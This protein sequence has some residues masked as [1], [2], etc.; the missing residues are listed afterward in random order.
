MFYIKKLLTAIAIA[1]AVLAAVATSNYYLGSIWTDT[2]VLILLLI[3]IAFQLQLGL[4]KKREISVK[5]GKEDIDIDGVLAYMGE[6]GGRIDMDYIED[7]K[8]DNEQPTY[9][10]LTPAQQ[11]MKSEESAIRARVA[12]TIRFRDSEAFKAWEADK[13]VPLLKQLG[14]MVLYHWCLIARC[15]MEGVLLRV[16][17]SDSSDSS[18]SSGS[19]TDSSSSDSSSSSDGSSSDSSD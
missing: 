8:P 4:H 3:A 11:V 5:I 17:S 16:D 13:Q 19:S 7:L 9:A 18:S 1:F 10:Q 12:E 2:I 14:A 15:E 6:L